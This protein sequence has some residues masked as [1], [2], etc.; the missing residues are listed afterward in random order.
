MSRLLAEKV[1]ILLCEDD[2]NLGEL[3][4]DFLRRLDFDVTLCFDGEEALK[5]FQQESFDLCLSDINMPQKDGFE[6]LHDIREMGSEVPF[7]F[8]SGRKATEDIVRAYH[9][10]C[11]DYMVKPYSMDILLCKIRALLRRSQQGKRNSE[12]EFEM[13]NGV[14]FDSVR[15]QL[16]DLRLSA[17]ES[18][19]LLILCR[20]LNRTVDRNVILRTIWSQNTYFASRSL[21]VY[22]NHLRHHLQ[23]TTRQIN[24]I[25]GKGYKLIEIEPADSDAESESEPVSEGDS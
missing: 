12:V 11:D 1:R 24:S 4:A 21:S 23:G 16:G 3:L 8:L 18:D 13:G 22:V 9:L 6:L 7:M 2:V 14:H 20:N 15:Q 10:G 19:L 5:V 17:R 25:H